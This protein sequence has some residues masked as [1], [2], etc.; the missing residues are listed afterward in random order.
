MAKHLE[1]GAVGADP[2][3]R[4]VIQDACDYVVNKTS[5]MRDLI[6]P[7]RHFIADPLRE[8]LHASVPRDTVLRR[9]KVLEIRLKRYIS[10]SD[11]M[12]DKP[13]DSSTT[14]LDGYQSLG[15]RAL[16]EKLTIIDHDLYRKLDVSSFLERGQDLQTLM[17]REI[18]LTW[19]VTECLDTQ[20]LN[21][22][23]VFELAEVISILCSRYDKF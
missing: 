2:F 19:S 11:N 13:F 6:V 8:P 17:Q 10:G 23:Q 12:W 3:I 16:A 1:D 7:L 9:K 22:K 18:D 21:E 20:L 5:R 4:T 15:P 14:L